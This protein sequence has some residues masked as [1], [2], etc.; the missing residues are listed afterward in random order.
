MRR[1][2]FDCENEENIPRGESASRPNGFRFLNFDVFWQ[3]FRS[4]TATGVLDVAART[5]CP[6]GSARLT[7]F[8]PTES[9]TATLVRQAK[10]AQGLSPKNSFPQR[11]QAVGG[12]LLQAILDLG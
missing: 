12:Q 4:R 1:V 3:V 11:N 10:V 7:R 9:V 5:A 6:A 2:A 8:R